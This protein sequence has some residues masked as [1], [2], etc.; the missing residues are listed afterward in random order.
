MPFQEVDEWDECEYKLAN[1]TQPGLSP[2]AFYKSNTKQY[3]FTSD[4]LR[5]QA[6][7]HLDRDLPNWIVPVQPRHRIYVRDMD[8]AQLEALTREKLAACSY[9]DAMQTACSNIAT[10]FN[11][12]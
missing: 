6:C 1:A 12:P 7:T 5:I 11:H 3:V 10:G 2:P 8:L 4:E 9:L